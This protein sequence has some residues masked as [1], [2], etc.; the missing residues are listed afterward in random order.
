M[1]HGWQANKKRIYAQPVMIRAMPE[2]EK[3][4][5]MRAVFY[6][7]QTRSVQTAALIII[8]TI[9]AAMQYV[10]R[11]FLSVID[12]ETEIASA[13]TKTAKSV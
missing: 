8:A 4:P 5:A 12:F 3:P 9:R 10:I 2:N 6:Y 1:M 11:F 13:N 7:F